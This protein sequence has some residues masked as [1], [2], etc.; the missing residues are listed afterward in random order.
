[1]FWP[2]VLPFRITCCVL[3]VAV[4]ALTAFASPKAWSR[5]KALLLYSVIGVIAFVPSCTGVMVAVDAFRFG[6]FNYGS[7]D[8]IQDA[9]FQRYM[10]ESATDI[11][12]RKRPGG[13]DARYK[14]SPEAFDSYL[15]SLWLQYGELSSV[16]RGGF[17]DEGKVVDTDT[18]NQRFGDPGWDCPADAIVYYGPSESDG[19]GA[20]YYVDSDSNLVFQH[21]GFW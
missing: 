18:F 17:S 16:A 3:I 10:P 19:G 2:F 13:F 11:Q 1:M 8:D 6:D 4:I 12:M 14:L 9:R 7:Y 20:V 15:D 5:V 21:T